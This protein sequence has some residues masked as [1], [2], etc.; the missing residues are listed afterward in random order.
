MQAYCYHFCMPRLVDHAQRRREFAVAVWGL[1][2]ERGIEGVTLRAVA[3]EAGVSVG[4][5]QHYYSTRDELVQDS[6]RAMIEMAAQGFGVEVD[7]AGR[8]AAPPTSAS[9][10]DP[11]ATLR[12]LILH[13]VPTTDTFRRGAAVWTAYVAKSVDDP[14]IADLIA[15]AQRGAVAYTAGLITAARE[16]GA[17]RAG[18]P[19]ADLALDLLACGDGLATRVLT[20]ALNTE[21]A[22]CVLEGRL[23]NELAEPQADAHSSRHRSGG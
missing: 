8:E 21:E 6:C 15:D 16:A 5:V 9:P 20:G 2:A 17:M 4:R 1:I 22:T 23:A 13:A 11:A 14:V 10:D 7:E 19:A 12:A 3:A 18:R